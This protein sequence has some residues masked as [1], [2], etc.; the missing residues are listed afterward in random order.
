MDLSIN[1]GNLQLSNPFIAASGTYG[2]GIEWEGLSVPKEFGAIVAKGIFIEPRKG[3]PHPRLA[4]TSAGLIN[5]IGL[6]GPGIENFLDEILPQMRNLDVPCIANINGDSFDEY[7]V[8]AE[9]LDD[10]DGVDAV[11][12]NVSCPNLEKGGMAFGID[13]ESVKRITQFVADKFSGPVIVKLTPNI[14]DIRI[15][16]KAALDGGADSLSIANT[17]TGMSID[18]FKRT[19]RIGRDFGGY[20]GPGIKPLTLKLVHDVYSEYK[21]PIIASGGIYNLFDCLEYF[22]AGAQALMLGTV[23]FID[24]TRVVA[25]KKEVADFLSDQKTKLVDIIGSYKSPLK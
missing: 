15:T 12:V 3:N 11:E 21:C 17:Y 24:P 5:S 20:S 10:Q 1:V 25:L 23:N 8:L 4:E 16:A 2:F 22:I 13:P 9:R 7:G 19:S 18:V 6:E 14:T